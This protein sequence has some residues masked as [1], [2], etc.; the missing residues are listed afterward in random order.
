MLPDQGKR[1]AVV[2]VC[3]VETMRL[4]ELLLG[5]SELITLHRPGSTNVRIPCCAALVLGHRDTAFLSESDTVACHETHGQGVGCER[6]KTSLEGGW[7]A[8]VEKEGCS[9]DDRCSK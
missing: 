4:A 7:Q 1:L 8:S 3:R 9:L 6:E 5:G 2:N